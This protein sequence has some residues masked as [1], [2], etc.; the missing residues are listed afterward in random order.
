MHDPR[1]SDASGRAAS[2]PHAWFM[3]A[4]G[5][6]AILATAAAAVSSSGRPQK[7]APLTCCYKCPPPQAKSWTDDPWRPYPKQTW[8]FG[9]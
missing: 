9:R 6:A 1:T 5:G 7:F 2:G 4:V 8:W 3:A